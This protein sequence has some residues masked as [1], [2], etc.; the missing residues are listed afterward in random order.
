MS[1]LLPYVSQRTLITCIY[2]YTFTRVSLTGANQL[3]RPCCSSVH[4]IHRSGAAIPAYRSYWYLSYTIHT[5]TTILIQYCVF[6]MLHVHTQ[7]YTLLHTMVIILTLFRRE[8][9][10]DDS[11]EEKETCTK[12]G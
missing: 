10:D 1:S 11:R 4:T 6:I 8:F 7:L 9:R 12:I 2:T 3:C 5:Y